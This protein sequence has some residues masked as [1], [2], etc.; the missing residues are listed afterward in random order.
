MRCALATAL[1]TRYPPED[2]GLLR[3]TGQAVPRAALPQLGVH[4]EAGAEAERRG[5][6][7]QRCGQQRGQL[8]GA[9]A[10]RHAHA[11]P[12]HVPRHLQAVLRRL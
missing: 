3:L 4:V 7:G 12:A 11:P 1:A 2:L 6:G 5:Q 10:R 8:A 9:A